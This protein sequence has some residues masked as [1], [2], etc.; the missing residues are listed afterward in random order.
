MN[1]AT[2][3]YRSFVYALKAEGDTTGFALFD[4]AAEQSA[5]KMQSKFEKAFEGIKANK[6]ERE[7]SQAMTAVT[8]TID[9]TLSRAR[10]AFGSLD[11]GGDVAS[12]RAA[13]EAAKARAIAADE[14]SRALSATA[15]ASNLAV[16]A[17]QLAA[18]EHRQAATA[19]VQHADALEQVQAELNKTASATGN[20]V[21]GM[22]ASSAEARQF[23]AAIQS[24]RDRL[25]PAAAAAQKFATESALLDKALSSGSLSLGDHARFSKL[26]NDEQIKTSKSLSAAAAEARQFDAELQRLVAHID[27]TAAATQNYNRQLALLNTE[28]ARTMLGTQGH[29]K[30]LQFIQAELRQNSA[31][32]GAQ[33]QAYVQLGQQLQDVAIQ[34]QMGVNPFVILTQQGTQAAF[35]MSQMGGAAGKLGAIMGSPWTIAFGIAAAAVYALWKELKNTTEVMGQVELASNALSQSQSV[36]A[37]YFDKGSNA[38]A[39]QNE[40]LKINARLQAINLRSDAAKKREEADKVLGGAT[41]YSYLE[42]FKMGFTNWDN[43]FNSAGYRNA[44]PAT[45]RAMRN[46][47]NVGNI[48]QGVRSGALSKEAALRLLETQ[49]FTGLRESKDNLMKQIVN[50][51]SAAVNDEIAKQLDQSIDQGSPTSALKKGGKKARASSGARSTSE[52]ENTA[53]SRDVAKIL[54]EAFGGKITSTDRTKA[55]NAAAGGAKASY[56]L[57]GRAVDFV[58]KGGMGSISK[59]QIRAVM[60]AA[61]IDVKQV[62]GPGD[63]GHDDHYHVAFSGGKAE[64]QSRAINE[65]LQ[66]QRETEIRQQ[67]AL[68]EFASDTQDKVRGIKDSFIEISP[69]QRELNDQMARLA[70]LSSDVDRKLSEGLNPE[71]AKALKAEIAD[72]AS[73]MPELLRTEPLRDMLKASKERADIDKLILAGKYDEAEV[74]RELL[75]RYQDLSLV[76]AD[77][78]QTVL[79]IARA[80]RERGMAIRD[81]RAIFDAYLQSVQDMRAGLEATVSSAMRG[82]LSAKSLLRSIGDNFLNIQSKI[83]VEKLFGSMLR[84]LE[85]SLYGGNGM[86]QASARMSMAMDSGSNATM[87]FANA[88]VEAAD[89]IR[90]GVTQRAANDNAGPLGDI[91]AQFQMQDI[92]GGAISDL[93][94]AVAGIMGGQIMKLGDVIAASVRQTN[95]QDQRAGMGGGVF[96]S[97]IERMMKTFGLKLPKSVTGALGKGFDGFAQSALPRAV[98]GGLGVK[99]STTG[100]MI[101]GIAGSFLPIPG[102]Q[103]IGSVIGSVI[104]GLFK[105]TPKGSLTLSNSGSSYAGSGKLQSGLTGLGDSVSESLSNIAQ[106]LGGSVGTFSSSIRQKGKKYYVNGQKFTD[107]DEAARALLLQSIQQGAIQ[108]IRAGAQKLLQAGKDIEVQLTKALKLQDVYDRLKA[109]D[110]PMGAALDAVDREFSQL[111]SIF[112]EAGESLVD[113]ERLYGKER[114]KAVEE[115]TAQMTATLKGLLNDL[116]VGDNGLSLRDRRAGALAAYN[117]LAADIA[118]GKAVDYDKYAAAAQQLLQIERE[119]YGSQPE[120]FSRLKEVTGATQKAL[121]DQTNIAALTA[122]RDSIFANDNATGVTS[123]VTDMNANL[124][125]IMQAQLGALNFNIAALPDQIAAKIA[126]YIPLQ[127]ANAGF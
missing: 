69:Y 13:A 28:Q 23:D 11:L 65:A 4:R 46:S 101:G 124:A 98:L 122:G 84:D 3:E 117:P 66:R 39:G 27:P 89:V 50:I 68:A 20:F 111:R 60:Q 2:S 30:A 114:A 1:V 77:E 61:G 49:D 37:D 62:L 56:H 58:P 95:L 71:T 105:K 18:D 102:G 26:L 12:A 52:Y 113:L 106:Q 94:S 55:A 104:G 96:A 86:E 125:T 109:Y 48:V 120:Y 47:A 19:A 118:A 80:E 127:T 15:G 67:Q 40:L 16:K 116:T 99:Q 29:A 54:I 35:A 36:L 10:N 32:T 112:I 88:A 21:K 79:A 24:L 57:T 25:D 45:Q 33:R 126:S 107:A 85:S 82:K 44:N 70:D 51:A 110:D 75:S 8:R 108:G 34:A 5:A 74:T 14:L 42:R 87:A 91:A 43:S 78:Y 17:A 76:R 115:V 6:L 31:A 119:I 92:V 103:I 100:A 64:S 97:Q 59:D 83:I 22:Q 90:R 81:Q 7:F 123:A 63:K 73:K 72:L 38:I 121:G 53:S 41:N 93:G 9:S